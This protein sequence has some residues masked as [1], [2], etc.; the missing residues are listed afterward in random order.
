MKLRTLKASVNVRCDRKCGWWWWWCTVINVNNL[1]RCYWAGMLV[2]TCS[3]QSCTCASLNSGVQN[4][5]R[6]SSL[7]LSSWSCGA[8]CNIRCGACASMLRPVPCTCMHALVSLGSPFS[9]VLASPPAAPAARGHWDQQCARIQPVWCMNGEISG[10]C[11]CCPGCSCACMQT[12]HLTRRWVSSSVSRPPMG[13]VVDIPLN[14]E[15]LDDV[16]MR[17]HACIRLNAAAGAMAVPC[18]ASVVT[19]TT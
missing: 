4:E 11:G 13:R 8:R 3:Q 17:N 18:T 16:L 10:G 1:V 2:N 12:R 6:G 9:D 5:R 15:R 7:P 14:Q 19:K